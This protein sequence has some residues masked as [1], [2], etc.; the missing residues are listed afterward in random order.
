MSNTIIKICGL[1]T[2]ETLNTAIDAG[3][4]W[5]GLV[6]FPPS[7]RHVEP[8]DAKPLADKARGKAKIV[9]LSVNAD[10]QLLDDIMAVSYTHLT[11]PTTP[12]V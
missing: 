10:D 2:L 8:I 6:T 3:A 7:P 11:L 9:S 4:D 12:Y 5:V 1:S